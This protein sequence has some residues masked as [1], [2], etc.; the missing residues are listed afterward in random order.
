M[1]KLP[2]TKITAPAG[3]VHSVNVRNA[4]GIILGHISVS[5]EEFTDWM[6]FLEC[7]NVNH[8]VIE[9]E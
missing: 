6:R 1:N 4:Q 2:I 5:Q 9:A 8:E 3:Q 7:H